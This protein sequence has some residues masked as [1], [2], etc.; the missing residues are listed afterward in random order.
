VAAFPGGTE[1]A[2]TLMFDLLVSE[3]NPK[4]AKGKKGVFQFEIPA[5]DGTTYEHFVNIENHICTTGAGQA[6]DPDITIGVKLPDMLLMG[7]G[8]LPGAKAFMTGKLKIRGNPLFG[9]KLGEW[10]DH[11]P[12]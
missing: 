5:S 12:A 6:A 11:P 7:T 2:L 3:F 10:F 8:K 4:K 1:A 9:T